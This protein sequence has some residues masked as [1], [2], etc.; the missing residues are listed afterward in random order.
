MFVNEK[1]A[2]LKAGFFVFAPLKRLTIISLMLLWNYQARF[3]HNF[4]PIISTESC[5]KVM[6][7]VLS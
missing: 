5:K 4:I 7:H 1:P 2:F 3:T 6:F